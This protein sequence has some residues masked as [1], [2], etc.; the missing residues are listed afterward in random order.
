MSEIVE[1]EDQTTENDT[2]GP[3]QDDWQLHQLTQR[4]I[5]TFSTYDESD[6]GTYITGGFIG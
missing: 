3:F 1:E 6:L 5:N 2:G 4:G